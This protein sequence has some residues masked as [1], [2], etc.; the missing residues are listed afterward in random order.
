MIRA[1]KKFF[2]IKEQEALPKR[3]YYHLPD[4]ELAWA[5]KQMRF[6]KKKYVKIAG[7]GWIDHAVLHYIVS[8][9]NPEKLN[10][11]VPRS[12]SEYTDYYFFEAA[13][14]IKEEM[15]KGNG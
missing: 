12:L 1:I 3:N 10:T 13:M 15:E 5:I 6:N 8:R 2:G 14:Q 7:D 4:H 11:L 9:L